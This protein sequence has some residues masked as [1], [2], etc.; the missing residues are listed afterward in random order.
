MRV[1]TEAEIA[2]VLRSL[3]RPLHLT[4]FPTSLTPTEAAHVSAVTV[5]EGYN[6]ELL[7][8]VVAEKARLRG[9]G[10]GL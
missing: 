4:L 8:R 2:A 9:S 6:Y 7:G 5:R 10:G 1:P 3:D